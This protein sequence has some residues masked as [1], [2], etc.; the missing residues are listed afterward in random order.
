M[1]FIDLSRKCAGQPQRYFNASINLIIYGLADSSELRFAA[2]AQE[3][4]KAGWGL[5]GQSL[6]KEGGCEARA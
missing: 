2:R 6:G 5:L 3:G 4:S 1:K